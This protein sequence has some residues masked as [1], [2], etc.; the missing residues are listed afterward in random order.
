MPQA[1]I[2]SK[3]CDLRNIRRVPREDIPRSKQNH[4]L[5]CC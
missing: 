5:N 4:V 1:T 3:G 2:S